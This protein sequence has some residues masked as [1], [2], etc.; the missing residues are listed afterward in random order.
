[1][2]E[3]HVQTITRLRPSVRDR[4]R[5]LAGEDIE[6][7]IGESD[8]VYAQCARQIEQALRRRLEEVTL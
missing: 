4:V 1:M 7:P 8:E 6:D 2:T 5:K 3:S